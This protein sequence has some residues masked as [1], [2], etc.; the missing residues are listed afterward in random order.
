M[1]IGFDRSQV[2]IKVVL[3]DYTLD[4]FIIETFLIR[5]DLYAWHM[6]SHSQLLI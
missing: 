1:Q 6:L 2:S 5:S 4:F 3:S